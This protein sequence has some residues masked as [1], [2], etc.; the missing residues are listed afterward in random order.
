MQIEPVKVTCE[1]YTYSFNA[2]FAFTDVFFIG[3]WDS[4]KQEIKEIYK[5]EELS[6][7]KELRFYDRNCFSP[8]VIKLKG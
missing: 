1:G 7:K 4:E 8:I 5:L 2:L 3:S 6:D